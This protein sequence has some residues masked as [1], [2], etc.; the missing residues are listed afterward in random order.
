VI[1][2]FGSRLGELDDTKERIERIEENLEKRS[3]PMNLE[4]RLSDIKKR[5]YMTS[6][7]KLVEAW[8]EISP[9][10]LLTGTH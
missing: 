1:L 2:D 6:K 7:T 8:R 3:K 10:V 9:F 5:L 4:K